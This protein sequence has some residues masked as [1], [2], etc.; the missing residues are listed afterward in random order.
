MQETWVDPWVRKNHLEKEMATHFS[1]LAWEIPW[2]EDRGAWWATAHRVTRVGH[3]LVT[4]HQGTG[5]DT[6]VPGQVLTSVWA[7]LCYGLNC[8]PP[9]ISMVKA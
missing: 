6:P 8:L 1:V 4:N 5:P 3:D 7:S 2:T 9:E